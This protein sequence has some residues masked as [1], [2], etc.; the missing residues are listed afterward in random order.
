[1]VRKIKITIIKILIISSFQNIFND[2]PFSVIFF[3]FMAI[4]WT[5]VFV[6]LFW[7]LSSTIS[8]K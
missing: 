8:K 4:A 1:M 6:L 3:L 2:S 7:S 5:D